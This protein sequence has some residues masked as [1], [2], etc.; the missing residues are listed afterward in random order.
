MPK[1][2]LNF[3]IAAGILVSLNACHLLDKGKSETSSTTEPV[4]SNAPVPLSA[5]SESSTTTNT[6]AVVTHELP[7]RWKMHFIKKCTAIPSDQCSGYYGLTIHSNG[8]FTIGPGPEGQTITH[9]LNDIE[10]S[11]IHSLRDRIKHISNNTVEDCKPNDNSSFEYSVS[12]IEYSSNIN[13]IKTS[14]KSI[15]TSKISSDDARDLL[16]TLTSLNDKYYPNRFPSTCVNAI[17]SLEN[18]YRYI[19]SCRTDDDCTYLNDDFSPIASKDVYTI[20]APDECSLLP[21]LPVGNYFIAL[22]NQRDLI[23]KWEITQELCMNE[24]PSYT[25]SSNRAVY[26]TRSLPRCF[27]GLCKMPFHYR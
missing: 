27:N 22:A 17:Y 10:F 20:N 24:R 9:K 26:N 4:T 5:P 8:N 18:T 3:F 21:T 15:C 7:T 25:C 14:E 6:P 2:E 1:M 13:L 19:R 11:S 23:E 12:Y 16:S